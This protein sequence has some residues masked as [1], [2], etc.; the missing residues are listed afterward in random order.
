MSGL[1]LVGI[2]SQNAKVEWDKNVSPNEMAEKI[3]A[4]L[5]LIKSDIQRLAGSNASK[6]DYG[7]SGSHRCCV[8]S[9]GVADVWAISDTATSGSSAGNKYVLSVQRN[10]S[11]G[12]PVTYDSS[13]NEL[14]AYRGGMY[15]G[16]VTVGPGDVLSILVTK[17]GTPTPSTL[18]T[19]NF[20]IR[21][22]LRAF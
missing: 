4:A 21:Y 1:N 16:Q 15:L 3:N 9:A 6:N 12:S 10:G 5:L 18:T 13:V 22:K 20:I 11:S 19:S 2:S 17:T 7:D 8:N 14:F